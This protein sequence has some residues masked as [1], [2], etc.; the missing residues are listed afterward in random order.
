MGYLGAPPGEWLVSVAC[1]IGTELSQVT[2]QYASHNSDIV[3]LGKD[4]F[5]G[6]ISLDIAPLA[7][8]Q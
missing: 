3:R 2:R 4:F 8:R 5:P 6:K 1:C 7:V